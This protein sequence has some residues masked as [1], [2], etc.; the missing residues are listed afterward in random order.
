[1]LR[2]NWLLKWRSLPG[3]KKSPRE[4]E[5]DLYIRVKQGRFYLHLEEEEEE[6]ISPYS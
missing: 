2:R 5:T 1:M 4:N 3:E 6:L